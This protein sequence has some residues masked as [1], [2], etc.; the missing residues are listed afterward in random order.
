MT[1]R[2]ATRY[3]QLLQLISQI[4]IVNQHLGTFSSPVTLSGV[5]NTALAGAG[6]L[7]ALERSLTLRNHWLIDLETQ[8]FND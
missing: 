7:A 8:W 6:L 4:D 2:E 1:G 5:A 3:P